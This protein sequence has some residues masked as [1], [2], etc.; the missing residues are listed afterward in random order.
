MHDMEGTRSSTVATDA[1]HQLTEPTGSGVVTTILGSDTQTSL[2]CDKRGYIITAVDTPGVEI[3]KAALK[4]LCAEVHDIFSASVLKAA[5]VRS[6]HGLEDDVYNSAGADLT[7][8]LVHREIE[9]RQG[10]GDWELAGKHHLRGQIILRRAGLMKVRFLH[11]PR[12]KI[13]APGQNKARRAYYRNNPFGQTALLDAESSDLVAVWRVED[14]EFASV[15]FRVVRPISDKGRFFG[16]ETDVDL[17]F[18]LPSTGPDLSSLVFEQVDDG[19]MLDIPIPAEGE[20]EGE[21]ATP[22]SGDVG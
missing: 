14:P 10:I 5:K 13:P 19:L 21:G 3:V 6:E 15:R 8:A 18:I 7:R 11:D 17:D 12:G 1:A 4:P 2:H 22:M 16:A 20:T 9:V